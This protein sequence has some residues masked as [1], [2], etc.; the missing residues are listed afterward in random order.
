MIA[1]SLTLTVSTPL[2][3]AALL[4]LL[5]AWRQRPVNA[6]AGTAA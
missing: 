1:R 5:A 6:V 4:V 2:S 3:G